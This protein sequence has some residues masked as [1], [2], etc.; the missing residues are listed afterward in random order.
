MALFSVDKNKDAA[1]HTEAIEEVLLAKYQLERGQLDGL[2][3]Y[4]RNKGKKK[5][6]Q[7][8]PKAVS[9]GAQR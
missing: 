6:I 7:K 4:V 9:S 1:K 2:W 5:A 8:P 3:A